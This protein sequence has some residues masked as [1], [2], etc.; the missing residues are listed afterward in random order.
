MKYGLQY[1]N[2]GFSAPYQHQRGVTLVVGLAMLLIVALISHASAQIGLHS[3]KIAHNTKLILQAEQAALS[4]NQRAFGEPNFINTAMG[5]I[6][7]PNFDAWPEYPIASSQSEVVAA[8]HLSTRRIALPGYSLGT[9]QS[10]KQ[11]LLEVD[12]NAEL[13][14][15]VHRR[16]AQGWIRIGAN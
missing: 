7:E 14:E 11:I 15:R 10:I 13:H 6:D 1:T 12:A 16:I 5:F 2:A 4:T 9:N 8:A 3:E